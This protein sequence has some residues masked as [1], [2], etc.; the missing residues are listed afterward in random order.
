MFRRAWAQLLLVPLILITGCA[1]EAAVEPANLTVTPTLVD[2]AQAVGINE[3]TRSWDI[4][5]A[6]V[7]GDRRPDFLL[8]RHMPRAET[9][10]INRGD[11]FSRVELGAPADRH[12][13]SAAD[14][15]GDSQIDFYCTVGARRGEGSGPNNL[16]LQQPDGNFVDK[17]TAFGVADEFGR[18]RRATFINANG[19]P[20]PDLYVGNSPSRVDGELSANRLYINEAGSGFRPA[21]EFGVDGQQ[22]AHCAAAVDLDR[23][24]FDELLL[25]G[26]SNLHLF[27]NLGGQGFHDRGGETG[28]EGR[29]TRALAADLDADKR[30]ELIALRHNRLVILAGP[31]GG[32]G[33]RL[34]DLVLDHGQDMATGDIDGDGDLDIFVVQSGCNRNAPVSDNADSELP[35]PENSPAETT[36]VMEVDVADFALLNRGGAGFTRIEAPPL[37]SGCG[38]QVESLDIDGDGRSEFLVANGNGRAFGPL[39]LLSLPDPVTGAED[40]LSE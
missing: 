40:S 20:W 13:C 4:E 7:N 24:G 12:D 25:C 30:V 28:L 32:Y 36:E 19:D 10:F 22:D 14:V 37:A 34:L 23:D 31:A 39:Q 8:T 21:P 26:D 15:N 3:M 17:A 6:D 11:G 5:V 27:Q 2:T 18:G 29:W 38:Q 1:R 33:T 9:L 16:F 35:S